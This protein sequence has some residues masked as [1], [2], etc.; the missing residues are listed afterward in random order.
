[1]KAERRHEL[2]QN[3]LRLEIRKVSSFIKAKSNIIAWALL[4]VAV[5]VL[6]GVL[7]HRHTLRIDAELAQEFE[8]LVLRQHEPSLDPAERLGLLQSLAGRDDD[9][10]RRSMTT[11][12][13]GNV[14]LEA[15]ILSRN[16]DQRQKY[17]ADA[18]GYYN[19]VVNKYPKQP[20]SVAKAHMGL[21]ALAES[22]GAFDEARKQ[23]QAVIGIS[24]LTKYP[25]AAFAKAAE[26]S[27]ERIK[28]QPVRMA[29]TMPKDASTTTAPAE[30]SGDASTSTGPKDP[31][32][33]RAATGAATVPAP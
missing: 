9:D 17:Y 11:A 5:L 26:V 33:T 21:G 13:M 19:D 16:P 27:L 15:A 23:Y 12:Q 25:V 8:Q 6:A 4:G 14:C 22:Q 24:G 20:M 30:D 28:E 10:F 29:T 3:V 2:Q 31:A 7:W 32:A 1:M 18:K